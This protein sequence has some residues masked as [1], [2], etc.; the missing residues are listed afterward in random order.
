MDSLDSLLIKPTILQMVK[1]G[2]IIEIYKY[3]TEITFG[4]KIDKNNNPEKEL[5][6]K[7]P[8]TQEE[9]KEIILS[10]ARRS[11]RNI[12]RLIYANVWRWPKP[13]GKPYTPI[14]ITLTFKDNIQDVRTGNMEFTKFIRRLN[15]EVG[16]FE[17]GKDT[18]ES[19]RSILQ[20]IAV[21]EFQKRGSVHYHVLFFNLPF[22]KNIYDRMKKIWGKGIFNINGKQKGSFKSSSNQKDISKVVDYYCKYVT[23]DCFDQRLFGKKKFFPSRGLIKPTKIVSEEL[24]REVMNELP[25][26]SLEWKK[27]DIPIPYLRSFDYYRYNLANLPKLEEEIT[28][29]INPFNKLI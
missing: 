26:E 16:I 20:Y 22:M 9:E 2:N 13:D 27:E 17:H 3:K 11:K 1:S 14:P 29:Y 10:S 8:L 18:K 21:I 25:D 23:K 28:R 19:K 24:V 12:K 6:E 15:Y 4:R 5:K 7:P